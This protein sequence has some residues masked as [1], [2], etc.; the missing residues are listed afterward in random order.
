MT[1][2]HSTAIESHHCVTRVNSLYIN[3]CTSFFHFKTGSEFWKC[4]SRRVFAIKDKETAKV[5]AS[6]RYM[7]VNLALKK[8]L[9]ERSV[10]LK[11]KKLTNL[12]NKK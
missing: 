3:L 2:L 1:S 7:R 4:P 9:E 11:R 12:L 10:L 5:K 8:N 6:K